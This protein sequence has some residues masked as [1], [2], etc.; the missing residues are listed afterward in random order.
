MKTI[1]KGEVN[2]VENYNSWIMNVS[3]KWNRR[4]TTIQLSSRK[5][6]LETDFISCSL[7]KSGFFTLLSRSETLNFKGEKSEFSELLLE[8]VVTQSLMV[9][10]NPSIELEGKTLTFKGGVRK[11]DHTSLSNVFKL[12]EALL[13]EIDHLHQENMSEQ[14]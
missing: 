2:F 13:N 14:Q 5:T 7:T 11:K 6:D 3:V 10:K 1:L 4:I 9:T 8:S 12:F